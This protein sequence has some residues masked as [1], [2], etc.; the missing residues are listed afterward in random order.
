VSTPLTLVLQPRRERLWKQALVAIRVPL[1]LRPRREQ[2]AKQAGTMAPAALRERLSLLLQVF[3]SL[4]RNLSDPSSTV[5]TR[6]KKC[7][8]LV[9]FVAL[10]PIMILSF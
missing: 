9:S 2:P 8:A 1:V 6:F 10:A 3:G 4:F 5:G 7:V